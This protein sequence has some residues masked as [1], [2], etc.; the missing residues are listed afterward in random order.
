MNPLHTSSSSLLQQ[1]SATTS[2]QQAAAILPTLAHQV[3]SLDAVSNLNPSSTLNSSS[4]TV[5][6]SSTNSYPLDMECDPVSNAS[7]SSSS[8]LSSAN[9]NS[10]LLNSRYNFLL[11]GLSTSASNNSLFNNLEQCIGITTLNTLGGPPSL[12]SLA[13][14]NSGSGGG[15]A[16]DGGSDGVGVGGS[17][18]N[19]TMA[20]QLSGNHAH[21]HRSNKSASNAV[22]SFAPTSLPI[23]LYGGMGGNGAVVNNDALSLAAYQNHLLTSGG[24]VGP[25]GNITYIPYSMSNETVPKNSSTMT[26]SSSLSSS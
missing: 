25:N 22:H 11:S 3:N 26:S 18:G 5:N 20:H 10:S 6:N 16:V 12:F 13:R 17:G 2:L 23:G 8:S 4:L 7:L 14:G 21:L 15:G 9:P 24:G 19:S 1:Q